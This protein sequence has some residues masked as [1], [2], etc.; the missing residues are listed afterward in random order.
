M[1]ARL[2]LG[3][4]LVLAI[5]A[6]FAL[7]LG[8]YLNL[9]TLQAGLADL[10]AWLQREP[11][12]FSAGFFLLYVMVTALSV[13]GAAVLT[14]AAGA[15]FGLVAGTVLVSFASTLGATL[16][17]LT[18]RYLLREPLRRRFARQ[19]DTIDRGIARD[20]ILYLASLR[21]M[22]VFPFF[23]I[24]LLM[25]L[26]RMPA[27]T[28]FWVSQ[29]SML[30]G[31]LVYV[32]AGTQI[33]K[34]RDL[35]DIASPGLWLAFAL[36]ALM[37]WL[38]RTLARVLQHHRR[39]ARWRRPRRFD[40]NLVVIGGGAAGLVS[41]YLASALKARVTLVEAGRLGGDCLNTGCV[42]S[43][44]LIRCAKLAHQARSADDFGIRSGPVT[45]DFAAVMEHV[46][47]SI[48]TIEPHDSAERYAALGV[49]VL[50]GHGRIVDPWTVEVSLA[51]GGRRRLTTR[52]IVIAAGAEPV[53]PPLP[54]L[55]Q[56]T[57]LTSE[58]LWDT[59]SR[60][61]ALP[62]RLTILG[63]GPIG[64]E[65][66]QAFARLGTAVVQIE[67]GPRLLPREDAEVSALARRLLETD[68]VEILT[69]HA[70][71]RCERQGRGQFVVVE[72][73]GREHRVAFDL[74]LL[75]VGRRA[76]LK[77]YGLET[78][79]IDT[80]RT[81]TTNAWLETGYPNIYA[82][83]DV[84]G[85][86]QFTHTAAHQ[87]GYATLNAL[88]SPWRRTKVDT[89]A[90]P[91]VTFLDPE[92]AH[93]GLTEQ[94]AE[95]RGI[96]VCV[97]RY[98]LGELDRAITEGARTGF[99]KVLTPPDSDRLLGAT[100][101]AE[102]AGEMLAEFTLALQHGLGLGKILATIHP[103]PTWTEA[104]RF[105]AGQWKRA[106]APAWAFPWLE[107]YHRWRRRGG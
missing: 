66:A 32:N 45:V 24:N 83:G 59:L 13:P 1:K 72:H 39:Y 41:A 65:L 31:T 36:L 23:L 75:A 33:A 42:P 103:Y 67:R 74:L 69:G 107:R 88:F 70:A 30:P 97:T 101:V 68:G 28:F 54:G 3:A 77:G 10:R 79:G 38:G 29:L 76:R 92:I 21:L 46:Q 60:R 44:A 15:L 55:D 27:R 80:D 62:E 106:H 5:T 18:A 9:A 51:G 91:R 22:P 78:L 16:A 95:A 49:E 53:V 8:R 12:L 105:A 61:G 20:G 26:T 7:D 57:W 82:A 47:R 85:P 11:V 73:E 98:D 56:V 104:N 2:A 35:R 94:E 90:V 43:K 6:W 87:A 86:W 17:M 100:I 48:R 4:A 71:L 99:V 84:A 102:R 58:T 25:G 37:P 34:L 64:C 96:A 93:V 89:R 52:A 63:G 40:R 50:A 14:V 19:F 81:V